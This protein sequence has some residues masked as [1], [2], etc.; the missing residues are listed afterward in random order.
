MTD[1]W[2]F[3]LQTLYVSLVG[4][5]LLVVKRLLRDKLTP[6]WQYGVWTV[7]ALHILLPVQTIGKYVLL[8]LPLWVE[9]AK[10]LV[11]SRLHSA[12]ADLYGP[13][14]VTA[15]IPLITTGPESVTDWLFLLYA[16]GV[17]IMLVQY[18][19][20]Y[21]RL[22]RLMAGG[23]PADDKL[24]AQIDRIGEKYRL[25]SCRAV[26]IQGLP[27]PMV[28]GTFR[29]VLA[30]P[31]EGT[32]DDHVILHELL[33]IRYYDALQ[34]LFW[35][36]CRA[37]HWCN[38]FVRYLLN[39]ISND[40]E[41]LCD[42]R[43]L[44]RLEGEERRE[45]GISLLAMANDRYPR[46]P[47]TTSIS[48]GGQ[49]ITRRIEAIVRF[50]KYPKGMALA[51]V[52][53]TVMLL[54][55]SLFPTSAQGL[56]GIGEG[57]GPWETAQAEASLNLVWCSTVAGAIDT[58]AKG[59]IEGNLD[60]L[61]LASPANEGEDF[62]RTV[63]IYDYS[64]DVEER[65]FDTGKTTEISL[66]DYGQS[67]AI[68]NLRTLPD[69]SMAAE[70]VFLLG[71][72]TD[73][74]LLREI[75]ESYPSVSGAVHLPIRIT[76]NESWVIEES[77]PC[78]LYLGDIAKTNATGIWLCTMPYAPGR[79]YQ[80]TGETGTVT[81]EAL[82]EHYVS[83]QVGSVG[84]FGIENTYQS[85]P[86]P[87]ATFT[88]V[89]EVST[90]TYTFGGTQEEKDTLKS[91]V[92]QISNMK[93]TDWKPYFT[94]VTDEKGFMAASWGSEFGDHHGSYCREYVSTGWDGIIRLDN[95]HTF[96]F[97]EYPS[98]GGA[99]QIVW[100]NEVKEEFILEEV[101]IDES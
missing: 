93:K 80:A 27:S 11:E 2:G 74:P 5:L 35:C 99:V 51:S 53:V 82:T 55:A 22:R 14:D 38:P 72:I 7:L 86:D 57:A 29:P 92:L 48:N 3:L 94:D 83:T 60:Y 1:L 67:Y 101:T 65:Y 95:H 45:Y 52:C 19:V 13:V 76:G 69:G 15:P 66:A 9:T 54:F 43:V 44:E 18:L 78:V 47:G 40:M 63:Q 87:N 36:L 41:S 17:L 75:E 85:L 28:F 42:Q 71:E 6:R 62:V 70:L 24:Q 59:L 61:S 96:A 37:L 91:A 33:H 12:Y 64:Y 73:D 16:A 21:L 31:T 56:E 81:K 79:L 88:H 89:Q 10:L 25:K 46:A 68:H 32:L 98:H 77:G 26:V 100:N 84:F 4:G 58:Y 97:S 8:P 49:N 30:I 34:N 50:K 23:K 90:I 39:Q 20:S